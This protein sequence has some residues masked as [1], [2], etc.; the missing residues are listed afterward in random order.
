MRAKKSQCYHCRALVAEGEPHDCW[1]TTEAALT[2]TLPED[3]RDAWARLR[4]FATGLGEQRIYASHRS[5]MFSHKSC[6]F[7]V[8]PKAKALE[9]CFFLPKTVKHACVKRAVPSSKTKVCHTVHVKHRDEV[10]T[11]LT[12]WLADAFAFSRAATEKPEAS[13]RAARRKPKGKS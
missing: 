9:V 10:E 7:F 4:E 11:P 13:R 6:H 8:R 3:L 1:T 2:E 12:D 5:I